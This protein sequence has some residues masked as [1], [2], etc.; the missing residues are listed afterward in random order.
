MLDLKYMEQE[1][2]IPRWLLVASVSAP[3]L[4]VGVVALYVFVQQSLVNFEYDFVYMTCEGSGPPALSRV[5]CAQYMEQRFVVEDGGLAVQDDATVYNA[6]QFFMPYNDT[7]TTT[8]TPSLAGFTTR[9]FVYDSTAHSNREVAVEELMDTQF[10]TTKLAPD[11]TELRTGR[12]YYHNAPFMFFGGRS[13]GRS[14]RLVKDG[15]QYDV[16]LMVPEDSWRFADD[17]RFI[18]WIHNN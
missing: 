11:G 9:F 1:Q 8:T 13:S 12:D 18:G 15:V 17:F 3:L 6:L 4:I 5:S 14:D 7:S 16:R 2:H 10:I